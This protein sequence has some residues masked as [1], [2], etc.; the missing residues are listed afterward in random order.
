MPEIKAHWNCDHAFV[1]WR[2]DTKIDRCRGF[3]LERRDEHRHVEVAKTWLGFDAVA[4]P[5]EMHPSTE[6]P[7]QRFMWADLEVRSGETWSYRATPMLRPAGGGPLERATDQATGWSDPITI[8]P[9]DKHGISAFFNRGIVASQWLA[10]RLDEDPTLTANQELTAIVEDE[11]NRT[12]KFLGGELRQA[13]LGMLHRARRDGDTLYACLFELDDPELIGALRELGPRAHVILA[14][15]THEHHRDENKQARDELK[16]ARVH[17]VNRMLRTGLSHNKFAVVCDARGE[18]ARRV[19]T[20]ST[21]WAKTGLCTQANNGILIES[22]AVAG[23]FRKQWELLAKRTRTRI[24]DRLRDSNSAPRAPRTVHEEPAANGEPP[25]RVDVTTWFA[26]V[27][28]AEHVDLMAAKALI[29]RAEDGILF[30]M[31]FPGI[32]NTVLNFIVDRGKRNSDLYVHGVINQS[33]RGTVKLIRR[34]EPDPPTNVK[35]LLPAAVHDDLGHWRNELL[36]LSPGGVMVHSKVVVIDPWTN[37]VVMTG[38]HNLGHAASE[39]NDDNLVIVRGSSSLASAYAVNIMGI[40]TEYRWRNL[41]AESRKKPKAGAAGR[42]RRFTR[43]AD[44]PKAAFDGLRDDDGWQ[45]E[46]FEGSRRRELQFWLGE[47]VGAPDRAP[48]GGARR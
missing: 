20:G 48:V 1:V 38:S 2:Y 6:W 9:S 27:H 31:F 22:D 7:I 35:V 33:T 46:H 15:G 8:S 19:W 23:D 39:N 18:N 14:N 30:L 43:T 37:P 4:D 26:P 21:N 10:K 28:R 13:L 32:R 3:A 47:S 12:R 42:R 36:K 16:R 11:H 24:S 34:G 40:Y 17:V 45:R 29:D 44:G 41:R 25:K 5:D